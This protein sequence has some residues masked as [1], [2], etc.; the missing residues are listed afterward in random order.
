[1]ERVR[2]GDWIGNEAG[3]RVSG[4]CG[5]AARLLTSR[6]TVKWGRGWTRALLRWRAT[7]VGPCCGGFVLAVSVVLIAWCCRVRDEKIVAPDRVRSFRGCNRDEHSI[8][9]AGGHVGRTQSQIGRLGQFAHHMVVSDR[10][11]GRLGNGDA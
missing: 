6:F 10:A 11:D 5:E 9:G 1:M 2:A 8:S 7:G 4:R 3:M